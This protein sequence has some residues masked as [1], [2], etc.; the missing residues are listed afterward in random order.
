MVGNHEPT[1][2]VVDRGIIPTPASVGRVA[3]IQPVEKSIKTGC[4]RSNRVNLRCKRRICPRPLRPPCPHL[5]R[6]VTGNP[7]PFPAHPT[8]DLVRYMDSKLFPFPSTRELDRTSKTKAILNS[9]SSADISS[10]ADPSSNRSSSSNA[11]GLSPEPRMGRKLSHQASDSCLL[12]KFNLLQ[13][14]PM[15]AN[16]SSSSTDYFSMPSP[17]SNTPTTPTQT[18]TLKLPT[19]REGVKKWLSAKKLFSFSSRSTTNT[20]G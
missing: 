6:K 15:I 8:N 13:A 1:A 20:P 16:I 4:L 11:P 14:P 19:T 7:F 18:P 3:S 10:G 2:W 17:Q 5:P 9:A 12:A